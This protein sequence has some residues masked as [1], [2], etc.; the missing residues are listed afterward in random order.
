MGAEGNR[1]RLERAPLSLVESHTLGDQ[2]Q[3]GVVGMTW[4]WFVWLT[5]VTC[6]AIIVAFI[7]A[8]LTR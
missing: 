6:V 5:V 7:Y 2:P 8:M 3:A 4:N 1:R